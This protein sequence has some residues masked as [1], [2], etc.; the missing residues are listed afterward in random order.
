ML[1]TIYA[2]MVLFVPVQLDIIKES[3][4]NSD[5]EIRPTAIKGYKLNPSIETLMHAIIPKK[6]VLHLH[7]VDILYHLVREKDNIIDI[8]KNI[9]NINIVKIPYKKPGSKI[10]NEIIY[11]R[12]SNDMKGGIAAMLQAI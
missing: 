10:A 7:A 1:E 3:I 12:G 6:I 4:L 9:V 2:K 11:G 5:F 8:F